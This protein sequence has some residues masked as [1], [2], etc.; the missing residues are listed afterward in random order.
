M[1]R[2]ATKCLGFVK[3]HDFSRAA[4]ATKIG[5]ASAPEGIRSFRDAS[6]AR[7]LTLRLSE[8]EIILPKMLWSPESVIRAR[9][10]IILNVYHPECS[11]GSASRQYTP[12]VHA[13]SWSANFRLRALGDCANSGEFYLCSGDSWMRL[14]SKLTIFQTPCGFRTYTRV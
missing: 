1:L 14:A 12:S 11:E 2:N 5:G 7:L 4:T 13:W 8:M 3:G 6:C 9:N 10:L